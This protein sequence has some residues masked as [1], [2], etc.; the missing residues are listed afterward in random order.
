MCINAMACIVAFL[1]TWKAL[2]Q[3][4]IPYLATNHKG[5]PEKFASVTF[6]GSSQL[7]TFPVEI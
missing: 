2:N 6:F 5:V 7:T 1:I 3:C 4:S